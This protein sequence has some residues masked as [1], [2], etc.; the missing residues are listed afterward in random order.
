MKERWWGSWEVDSV[1]SAYG[2]YLHISEVAANSFKFDLS[3]HN[4]AHMGQIDGVAEIQN[5]SEALY[6][7][8]SPFE[9]EEP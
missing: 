9:D 8:D 1:T 2:A 7:S 5:T 3:V 6:I 4:G